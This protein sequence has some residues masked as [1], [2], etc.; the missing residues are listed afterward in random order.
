MNAAAG[1]SSPISQ[2]MPGGD[3]PGDDEV[4]DLLED[5]LLD[6]AELLHQHLPQAR[7]PGGAGDDLEDLHA[8]LD[9]GHRLLADLFDETVTDVSPRQ[10]EQRREQ[11]DD[12]LQVELVGQL[13]SAFGQRAEQPTHQALAQMVED[14]VLELEDAALHARR[15]GCRGS[16]PAP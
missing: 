2:V 14:V 8:L 6:V 3:D 5:H 13:D 15:S 12:A 11:L 16:G 10:P 9:R 7:H 1:L 4:L